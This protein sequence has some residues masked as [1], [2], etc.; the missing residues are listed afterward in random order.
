MK[1]LQTFIQDQLQGLENIT[2]K[3][4][5][6]GVGFFHDG[7]MFGM[8]GGDSFRLKVDDS[9]REMYVERGLTAYMSSETKKGMPYYEVP[10]DILEDKDKLLE[11]V[12]VSIDI[13]HS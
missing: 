6:G 13:A 7:K 4:M 5:F 1:N 12:Q 3:K 8:I 11:W 2:S 9:N 10:A